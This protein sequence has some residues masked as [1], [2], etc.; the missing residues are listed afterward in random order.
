MFSSG[1]DSRAALLQGLMIAALV[2]GT[3]Y[4]AREVLLP[5][6]LAILLSFVLTP[7]LLLLRKIKVPRVLAVV[8]VV[9]LAFA[10]IFGLGWM[11]SQQAS[12]LAGDLPRYQHVLAE[13]I[14]ALRKSAS[15]SI[16]LER[17][18]GALKGIEDELNQSSAPPA[19]SAAPAPSVG[20]QAPAR[21]VLVEITKPQPR[22]FEI[23]QSVLGTVLPPLA[24]AG[25]VILFVIFILL[26]REDLR[27]RLVRLAGA[28]DMQRATATMNDAATRL[29]RYFLRQVLINS[30]YGVFIALGLWA[31]GIPSPM[32]WGILAMLM[33]FVPYVG[34]FIAAA[35]PVLLGTVVDPG[36]TTMVLTGGLFLGSELIMGQVVEPLVY[37]HGTGLSP[38]AV[39]LSTVFWTWL[40]G[41]L[42]LLLAMPLTVCLVVLGRHVEGLNFLE[43]MLG[44]KPAL[45]PAQSFYQRSLTGDSAEATYQAELCLKQG[46]PLVDY[47]D[48][49]AL[50]G[51]KLAE[52]DAERGSLDVENLETIDATVDEMMDNLTDFE[53]RRWFRK[54]RTEIAVEVE[55]A[56]NGLASLANLEE[57]DVDQIPMLEG[58]LAPG[59]EVEDAVLCIGGRTPL[60]EAVAR[61]LAGVLQRQGLK[62]RSL[63]SDA[64]SAAHIVSLEAS[65]T[66]LVCLS[67]FGASAHAA[68]VRYLVRRLRRILPEGATVLVGFW[69][70]EGGGAALKAL[71]ATADADAYAT[72]LKEAARLCVDA[73]RGH[74]DAKSEAPGNGDA[75]AK[76]DQ[77]LND[78]KTPPAK[79]A[80]PAK[81]EKAP[82]RVA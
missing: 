4:I 63:P 20:D 56:P 59:W 26:Q 53:P 48:D 43:V 50:G 47:L 17:A 12:Q 76:D 22:W 42:G 29:S 45:T 36:W 71:Q 51:L 37:G 35:P 23:L 74:E 5:L 79:A 78:A 82:A 55:D 32:V 25:I 46:R 72:T 52:R 64:I 60:D 1:S 21:P 80:K 34:P 10:I 7:L 81:D 9:T 58:E 28:S 70:D 6:A 33:R 2:V 68:H 13:K 73:A 15:S 57:E 54:V 61:M 62:A 16:A 31:I 24:T 66:K 8:I 40:W 49:V 75:A 67:Y 41:P 30:A 38:I 18:A 3:L 14:A 11:M 77:A 39:I 19:P 69:A 27:D 65:K 44:D